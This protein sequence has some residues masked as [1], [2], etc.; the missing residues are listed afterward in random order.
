MKEQLQVELDSLESNLNETMEK[1]IRGK[2][3]T[4]DQTL[5]SI[6]AKLKIID[7]KIKI[8]ML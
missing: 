1:M 8:S 6:L 5:Q 3:V 7:L 2:N 4:A